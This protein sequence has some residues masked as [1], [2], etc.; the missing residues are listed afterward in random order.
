MSRQVPR[1]ALVGWFL[2]VGIA[3]SASFAAGIA[4]P[5]EAPPS[6]VECG[7]QTLHQENHYFG[8]EPIGNAAEVRQREVLARAPELANGP[9]KA[10]PTEQGEM[11]VVFDEQDHPVAIFDIRQTRGGWL[12]DTALICDP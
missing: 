8:G 12:L 7:E 9:T 4:A 10:Y 11:H 5:Q 1:P 6:K 2:V 3:L